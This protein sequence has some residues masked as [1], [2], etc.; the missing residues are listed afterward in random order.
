MERENHNRLREI[1]MEQEFLDSYWKYYLILEEEFLSTLRYVEL[2]KD[3]FETFSVEYTKQYQTICS[4]I[5]VLCKHF[6]KII[7][8]SSNS[9]N[10]K[11]YGEIILANVGQITKEGISFKKARM[12]EI[13]PWAEWVVQEK[14]VSPGW[15]S[16]YNNV[17]HNRNNYFKE[18][19]L[20]NV[21]NALAGLY[22]LEVYCYEKIKNGEGILYPIPRSSLF[23]LNS[24]HNGVMNHRTLRELDLV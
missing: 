14:Y 23:T 22:V 20:G 2:H 8:P 21:I 12:E 13:Y 17:K 4:E 18:A 9:K 15:W 10:I 1:F 6:C 5:D 7:D 11:D 16:N 24:F 3:N 19:N